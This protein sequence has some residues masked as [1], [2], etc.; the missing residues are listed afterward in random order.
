MEGDAGWYYH[1]GGTN[2]WDLNA[3]V[4]YA[5]GGRGR[6][7]PP[8]PSSDDPFS[9]FCPPPP[10]PPQE[11]TTGDR[12]FGANTSLPDLPFNG[13]S[14]ELS[15]AFFGP[16]APPLAPHLPLQQQ[17]QQQAMATNDVPAVQMQ[18][19]YA[20]PPPAGHLQHQQAMATNDVPVQ[21]QQGYAAPPPAGH[22]PLQQQQQQAMATN[23]EPVQMQQAYAAAPPP[24]VPQTSGLQAS[25]GEGSSK[26]KQKKKRPPVQKEV[27]RVAADGVSADPWAWRKYGQKPIKGSPYPRGYYRCS[28]E[29]A[30][31]ARKMVERC[32]DDPDSFILTYTGGDHNHPAP[33]HRNSLAGTTRNKQHAAAGH[34][35]P[36]GAT[37]TAVAMAAQ[38]SPGQSTSGGTSASPTTSPRSPSAEECNQQEAECDEAGGASKDVEMEAEEDD[39]LKKLLDTAIGVGGASSSYAAMEHDGGAGVSP[40]LNVV[41]ETFVVTP[42]VTALGD[43]T[44]WS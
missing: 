8:P 33:I 39:E 13:N 24:P 26:S 20:A 34:N 18:Q 14:D 38:P 17:Q 27:K 23:G 3:V 37:A 43:A 22:L 5:C 7:S 21:M 36:G 29:K 6:V 31:E 41:E 40:F 32:R 4:R 19:G 12:L 28:T 16:P 1:S 9:T 30:C 25:G 35:A 15:I 10:A 44:G 11:L 2:D 42:W